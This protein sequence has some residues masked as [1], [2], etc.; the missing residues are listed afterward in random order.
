MISQKE[1]DFYRSEGYLVV[2]NV[3]SA[4]ELQALRSDLARV[5]AEASSVTGNNEIYD[6]EDSHTPEVYC[7][8]RNRTRP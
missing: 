2:E 7:F 4:E 1:V 8:S 3:V 5:L 6:L